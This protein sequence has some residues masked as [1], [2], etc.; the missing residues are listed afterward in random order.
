MPR[1]ECRDTPDAIDLEAAIRSACGRI[2]PLWPLRGF[3]AVN[4]FLG[5][6]D[7]RFEDTAALLRRVAG[8][9][10]L[11][12][13]AFHRAALASGRVTDADLE[14]AL[15]RLPSTATRPHSSRSPTTSSTTRCATRPPAGRST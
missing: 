6:A 3:V 5:F 11:M 14:V 12:P 10:M 9:D 7:R 8:I 13:R 2:A 4:P 1:F 15:S